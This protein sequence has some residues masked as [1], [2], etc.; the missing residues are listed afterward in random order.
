MSNRIEY[1]DYLKGICIFSVVMLH[2]LY[3]HQGQNTLLIKILDLFQMPMFFFLSGL[4]AFKQEKYD[5]KTFINLIQKKSTSLLLPYILVGSIFTIIFKESLF[6]DFFINNMHGGYWFVWV[7]FLFFVIT[8]FIEYLNSIIN[9]HKKLFV[10]VCLFIFFYLII[11]IAYNFL[12]NTE[13]GTFFSIPQIFRYIPFFFLGIL[14]NKYNEI[15]NVILHEYT[16][17]TSIIFAIT[18]GIFYNNTASLICQLLSRLFSTIIIFNIIIKYKE[19]LFLNKYFSYIGK[20]SLNIYIFHYF[21]IQNLPLD[22][23]IY[24]YPNISITFISVSIISICIICVTL[25]LDVIVN[26]SSILSFLFL[27]KNKPN[28]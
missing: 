1:I 5:K 14:Y 9:S 13:V 16:I 23:L 20:K 27:G 6:K 15:K 26:S 25:L 18:F 17:F 12:R 22:I 2:I 11:I 7:L 10:H 8:F 4:F 28:K 19:S 21:F 24:T 3:M